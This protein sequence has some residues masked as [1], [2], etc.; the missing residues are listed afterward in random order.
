M[1]GTTIATN[2]VHGYRHYDDT[3]KLILADGTLFLNQEL[4]EKDLLCNP[5][6][7]EDSTHTGTCTW[8][9]SFQQLLHDHGFC[10]HPFACFRPN[11]G[12]QD[13]FTCGN[14]AT[15]DL[16]DRMQLPIQCMDATVHRLLNH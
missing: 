3:D 4:N 6:C 2:Y 8:C 15:D 12:G 7:C 11:H 13:G 1:I 14:D 5:V 9:K 16:P 10:A